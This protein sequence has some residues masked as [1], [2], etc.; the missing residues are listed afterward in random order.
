MQNPGQLQHVLLAGSGRK[1]NC[2]LYE[3]LLKE[4]GHCVQDHSGGAGLE[5]ALRVCLY[6]GCYRIQLYKQLLSTCVRAQK[7]CMSLRGCRRQIAPAIH[8]VG[9]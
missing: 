1:T 5:G 2:R 3:L 7:C 8:T 9:D 6:T 4:A